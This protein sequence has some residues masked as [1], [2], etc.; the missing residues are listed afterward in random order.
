VPG[1]GGT[2]SSDESDGEAG[3]GGEGVDL[4]LGAG[5][6]TMLVV[7]DRSGSMASAWDSR[8]KWQV[9]NEAL[10]KAIEGV[11]DNLT[12]AAILFPEPGACEVAPLGA[13]SQI[14]FLPGRRF[15]STWQ[16]RVSGQIPEGSTP[17]EASFR[18]VDQAI[19]SAEDLGLLDDRFRV[20]LVTDGEPTCSDDLE[21][22]TVLPAKWREKGVET[23]VM[24]LP[25]SAAA[26]ELLDRIAE[27]G[28]TE[29]HQS[30]GNPDELDHGLYEAA[31]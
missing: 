15:S 19:A 29:Q 13:E 23:W 28:G 18:V 22:V 26:H 5:D 17:L 30:L 16:E 10:M 27:A 4:A 3:A 1:T 14:D 7:F 2:A 20:V 6:L 11:I 8:S 25:G 21:A 9:A 12:L 24:G 31:R